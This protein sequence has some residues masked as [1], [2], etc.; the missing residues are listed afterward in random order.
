MEK[1]FSK[2]LLVALMIV[3]I[4]GCGFH[5][6]GTDGASLNGTRLSVISQTPYGEFEKRLNQRLSASGA[7]VVSSSL[8]S[9]WQIELIELSYSQ[10]GV[11]RDE[12]GRANEFVMMAKLD[13]RLINLSDSKGRELNDKVSEANETDNGL[14]PIRSITANQSYYQD[15]RNTVGS[16]TQRRET[17]QAL[18]TM[19]SSQ[20][21]RQIETL[22]RKNGSN[23]GSSNT[24]NLNT[25]RLNIS[26]P[27]AN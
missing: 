12:T 26:S 4:S 27:Q 5:L 11:S 23:T 10:Q 20:L 8:Q 3:G 9:D 14:L 2:I 24:N 7:K 18:L 16:E 25:S 22:A 1:R 13:Y 21:V 19:L 6:R 17:R 15:Y